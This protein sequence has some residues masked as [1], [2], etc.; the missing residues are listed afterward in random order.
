LA[1]VAY[2]QEAPFNYSY[3]ITN[4]G[5]TYFSIG[6]EYVIPGTW[7]VV[8]YD[9]SGNS[10]GCTVMVTV[11]PEETVTCDITDWVSPFRGKPADIPNP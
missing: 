5:T 4:A 7:Q 6:G 11:K 9:A 3:Y 1:I 2:Q 8:A 10:G